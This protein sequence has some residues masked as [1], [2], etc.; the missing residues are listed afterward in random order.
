MSTFIQQ[1]RMFRF[2]SLYYMK[3]LQKLIIS[4]TEKLFEKG[5]FIFLKNN[6]TVTDFR[7]IN[8]EF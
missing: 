6:F 4:E 7:E 8:Y 3:I 5:S 2:M 1:S